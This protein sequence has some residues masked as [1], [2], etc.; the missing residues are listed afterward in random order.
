[1][2]NTKVTK[3]YIPSEDVSCPDWN[4]PSLYILYAVDSQLQQHG[5]QVE[6]F[7][8]DDKLRGFKVI[9]K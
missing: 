4:G 7:E 5:L 6:V 9:K 2:K 1:M 8:S 3:K